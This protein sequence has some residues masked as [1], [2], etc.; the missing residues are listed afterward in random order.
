LARASYRRRAYNY[1]KIIEG[2]ENDRPQTGLRRVS[3]QARRESQWVA[4]PNVVIR[5][6]MIGV[7]G[8]S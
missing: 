3:G 8:H 5:V 4:H 1:A 6:S 7:T 2:V